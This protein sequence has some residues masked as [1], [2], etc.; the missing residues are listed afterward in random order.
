M[1]RPAGRQNLSL[2]HGMGDE[3]RAEAERL[4]KPM[5]W[6]VHKCVRM[7]LPQIRLY[8]SP[9]TISLVPS[10]AEREETP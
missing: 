3:I 1:P 9:D 4:G 6:V 5:S 7:V 8:P 10:S 2:P